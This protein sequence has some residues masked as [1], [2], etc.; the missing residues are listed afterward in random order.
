MNGAPDFRILG[1]AGLALGRPPCVVVVDP[2]RGNGAGLGASAA[3][4]THGHADHCS[5][6]DLHESTLRSA[7]IVCPQ[8]VA[9]RLGRAFPGRVVGLAE[10]ST[11]TAPGVSVR[12]LP[13]QGPARAAGFHPR[14]EGLSYLVESGGARYLVLGASDA[15]P[16]HAHSAPDVAFVAVGDFTVMTPEE[17]A[18]AAARIAPRL[19]VPVHWGDTSARFSAAQRFVDLCAA[20]GVAADAVGDR[21]RAL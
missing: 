5:E 12:A 10:G 20:R 4:V 16:E 14:G 6:E 9:A 21:A 11:W 15:L 3:L 18:E 7:P 8:N 13:A 2:W 17:A 19:A 1:H